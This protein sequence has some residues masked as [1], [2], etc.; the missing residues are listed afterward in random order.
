LPVVGWL[1]ALCNPTYILLNYQ[2]YLNVGLRSKKDYSLNF[3]ISR[4]S[5]PNYIKLLL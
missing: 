1:E 2:K 4:A 3:D 5:P